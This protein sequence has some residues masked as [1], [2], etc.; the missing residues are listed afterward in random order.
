MD[1]EYKTEPFKH[2]RELVEQTSELEMYAIFWEQGTGKTKPIIDA[3]AW[4]WERGNIDA[5]VVVAPNG[6]HRN[7]LSDEFPAHFP[8]RH[9]K[10]T[11][12]HYYQSPKASTKW[13]Q[14]KCDQLLKH[15]GLSILTI[16]YDGFMTKRGKE[17]VKKFL[18]RRRA[19]YTLDESDAIKSPGAKRTKSIVASGAYAPYKR[20][21][22][23]TPITQ[24]PYDIYS[25]VRFLDM[26]FWKRHGFPNYT[27]FKFHFG[28]WMMR[29]EF[30]KL[31]GYDPGY[32]QLLSY[33]N[34]DELHDI[35]KTIGWRLTKKDAG[36]DL[37]PKLF[38]KRYHELEPVQQRAY[39]EL[40]S[41]FMTELEDGTIID[42]TLAIVRL[43]RFQQIVCGYA[44]TDS[45][46][47]LR[48]LGN[49]NPRLD[50]AVDYLEPLGHKAIVWARFTHDID[51]LMDALGDRAVRY[52]G[53]VSDDEAAKAKDDFQK[54]DAQYFVANQAKGASG[55][56]LH[57]AHTAYYYS[58]NFKLRDR[59]QSEDRCHRI[60]LEHPVNYVDAVCAGT[61]D[62]GIIRSL[63]TKFNIASQI[64]GDTVKDWI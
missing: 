49:K 35:L 44:Q 28:N 32:D 39:D 14:K 7:W 12:S 26:N 31:H 10:R 63:R 6:V 58:N 61:V 25:Q 46:E 24:G 4:H 57:A 2:Q 21:M 37:P 16:S 47:P 60:G 27:V 1:Y 29:G 48:L 59:L 54:G 3:I 5:A 41:E 55:I 36:I 64:N 17:Y 9:Y 53:K 38:S 40:K 62:D 13:H 23:G 51:Q 15:D 52:D 43:L 8:D 56:T 30:Q 33:K 20:I 18:I 50:S 19:F 34:L 22:T 11:L 45:E 42:G